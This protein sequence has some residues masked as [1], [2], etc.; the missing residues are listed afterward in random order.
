MTPLLSLLMVRQL[1]GMSER[2][3]GPEPWTSQGVGRNEFWRRA[4]SAELVAARLGCGAGDLLL[5][6]RM[7]E[8]SKGCDIVP[9]VGQG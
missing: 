3:R 2:R 9:L 8:G 5:E 4:S 1:A 7:V 6:G